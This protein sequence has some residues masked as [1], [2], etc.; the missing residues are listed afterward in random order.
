M[1]AASLSKF[2]DSRTSFRFPIIK[3]GT[4]F[5]K[6]R[7][8]ASSWL[9]AAGVGDDWDRFYESIASMGRMADS[10]AVVLMR[11]V[12]A[13]LRI[14][15]NSLIVFAID[16]WPTK[17]YGRHVDG[18]NI[19]HNPTPGPG[20][21]EW[22]MV[23]IEFA[24]H[25]FQDILS[26]ELVNGRDRPWDNSDRRPSRADRRLWIAGKMLRERFFKERQS[27]LNE[28]KAKDLLHE[29]LALAA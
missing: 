16:G 18:A 28:A 9:R 20:D 27:Q 23:T 14:D 17:R 7:R 24:W 12:V 11:A 10:I 13:Q 25:G 6:G 4:F 8:T 3:A 15:L 26:G 22:L 29:L 21:G 1:I 2:L 5:A 19:H